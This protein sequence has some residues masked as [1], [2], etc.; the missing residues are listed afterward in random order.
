ML[1]TT[2]HPPLATCRGPK[3][4]LFSGSILAWFDLSHDLPEI[5][6]KSKLAL[7]CAFLSPPTPC[8]RIHRL[9]CFRPTPHA[10]RCPG[11]RVQA[12]HRNLPR[13]LLPD[14]DRRIAK[15]RTGPDLDKRTFYIKYVTEPGDSFGKF[16][17]I[18]SLAAAQPLTILSWPRRS[19]SVAPNVP[20]G[21]PR[22]AMPRLSFLIPPDGLRNCCRH[23]GRRCEKQPRAGRG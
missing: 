7:F 22:A 11:Q 18:P 17:L 23:A 3:L 5:N 14:T 15:D 20:A 13:W 12:L 19:T 21:W 4:G 2:I 9:L 6:T 10:P 1:L 8:L 16:D